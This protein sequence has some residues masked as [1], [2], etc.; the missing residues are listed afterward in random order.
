MCVCVCVC[1]CVRVQTKTRI[2]FRQV[3]QRKTNS[4]YPHSNAKRYGKQKKGTDRYRAR[5]GGCQVGGGVRI[6]ATAMGEGGQEPPLPGGETGE[7]G[8]VADGR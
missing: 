1:V 3:R 8:A 6:K 5:V 2:F 7:A 4:V